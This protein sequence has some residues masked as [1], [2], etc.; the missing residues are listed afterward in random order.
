MGIGHLR[1]RP[2]DRP[3]PNLNIV[4]PYRPE[5]PGYRDIE[6]MQTTRRETPA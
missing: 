4:V 3:D 6:T 2:F 1:Q 5:A